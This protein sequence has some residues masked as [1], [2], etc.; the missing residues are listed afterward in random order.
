MIYWKR[1][2]ER[3]KDNNKQTSIKTIRLAKTDSE[4][5][6]DGNVEVMYENQYIKAYPVWVGHRNQLMV[7]V[8]TDA[9]IYG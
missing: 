8:E 7:K 5:R 6:W 2:K 1:V 3:Y 4:C 9:G